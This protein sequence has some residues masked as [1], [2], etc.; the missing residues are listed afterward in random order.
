MKKNALELLGWHPGVF[1]GTNSKGWECRSWPLGY[2]GASVTGFGPTQDDAVSDALCHA[3]EQIR[4]RMDDAYPSSSHRVRAA[5][6][7]MLAD[8]EGGGK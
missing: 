1:R 6:L 7:R 4:L 2:G 8:A 5:E 3:A